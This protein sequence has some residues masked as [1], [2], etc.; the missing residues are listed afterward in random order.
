VIS[1]E[2]KIRGCFAGVAIGDA[3]GVPWELCSHEEIQQMTQGRGVLGLEELPAGVVRRTEPAEVLPLGE[4]SDDWQLTQ[5]VSRSLVR[6]KKFDVHDMALS[7][8]AAYEV[9]T[10]GWGPSTKEAVAEF[11]LYFDSRGAE[12]RPPRHPVKVRPNRGLGNGV[13]M[14]MSPLVCMYALQTRNLVQQTQEPPWKMF[15]RDLFAW[16][17]SHFSLMTHRETASLD[18]GTALFLVLARSDANIVDPRNRERDSILRY[19]QEFR[20]S[21]VARKLD[22][23]FFEGSS[24]PTA[25]LCRLSCGV[26][27]SSTTSAMFALATFFRHPND[28]SAA[29]LEVVNAGGDTDT[30]AAIAGSLVGA[31]VGLT[32]IPAAWQKAVPAVSEAIAAADE[33][34]SAFSHP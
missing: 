27:C 19:L 22:S 28:F 8:V 32:G 21:E 14:K 29:V 30:N 25:D 7:H 33:L 15:R 31:R 18:L 3:L 6:R 23:M 12:G 34:I 10:L 11:K 26:E 5:A 2:D 24:M 4:T 17:V 1:L 13:L 20:A 9:S 16:D